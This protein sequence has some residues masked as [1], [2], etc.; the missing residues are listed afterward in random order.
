[1]PIFLEEV[2]ADIEN[3]ISDKKGGEDVY[4]IMQMSK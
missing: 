2:F 3:S 1:L 4:G